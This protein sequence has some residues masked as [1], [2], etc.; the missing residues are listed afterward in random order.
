M[1]LIAT[2]P[3]VLFTYAPAS[4]MLQKRQLSADNGG[5]GH[6]APPLVTRRARRSE[7]VGEAAVGGARACETRHRAI[8]LRGSEKADSETCPAA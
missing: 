6:G 1:S 7:P 5:L 4:T 2:K 3:F 8:V